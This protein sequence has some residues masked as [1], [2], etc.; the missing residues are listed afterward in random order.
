[1][2]N[3]QRAQGVLVPA[4][5]GQTGEDTEER[6]AGQVVGLGGAVQP[7][8]AGDHGREI[9]VEDLEGPGGAGLR[10]GQDVVEGRPV[11]MHP[12]P[13]DRSR[14]LLIGGCAPD[15][16][17]GAPRTGDARPLRRS[18]RADLRGGPI[19]SPGPRVTDPAVAGPFAAGGRRL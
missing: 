9:A 6:L 11:R 17:R 19:R 1:M 16:E 15:R 13:V 8:V 5:A 7:Q 12:P 2:V 10:G 3:T 14:P 4:E 18:L